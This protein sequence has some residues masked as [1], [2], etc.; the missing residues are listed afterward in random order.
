M[1]L[2]PRIGI[3]IGVNKNQASIFSNNQ[4][5]IINT[6]ESDTCLVKIIQRLKS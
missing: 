3:V 2:K 6:D 4:I 1:N 5:C